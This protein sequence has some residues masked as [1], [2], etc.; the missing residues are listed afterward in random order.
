MNFELFDEQA[1]QATIDQWTAEALRHDCFPTEVQTRLSIVGSMLS[2]PPK[3]RHTSLAYGVFPSGSKVA[4]CVCDLLLTDRG[5]FG[6][7]WLKMLKI[8]LSPEIETLASA[9]DQ[10][11]MYVAIQ[12]Y[13]AAVLGSFSA[14]LEHEAD[15]LK[16]YGRSKEQLDFLSTMLSVLDEEG[17]ADVSFKMEG[18][19]LVLRTAKG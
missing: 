5:S 8:T 2:K 15:T 16:L 12:S 11:A 13:K 3:E 1:Y 10:Q 17:S 9:R 18:R 19:W 4:S 7:K 6:G 14:R